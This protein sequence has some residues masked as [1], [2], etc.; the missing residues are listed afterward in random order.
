MSLV[1]EEQKN[2]RAVVAC[3]LG[4]E[5]LAIAEFIAANWLLGLHLL[6]HHY[7]DGERERDSV[8]ER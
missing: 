7:R 3:G 1:D 6:L 2:R 8:R 5:W 4:V